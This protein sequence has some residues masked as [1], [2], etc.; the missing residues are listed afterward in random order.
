MKISTKDELFG[1]IAL[2]QEKDSEAPDQKALSNF[3]PAQASKG[4]KQLNPKGS[5]N[6]HSFKQMKL[7]KS[8][9][10]KQQS[11]IKEEPKLE[12]KKSTG[13]FKIEI[14]AEEPRSDNPENNQKEEDSF[15]TISAS[16]QDRSDSKNKSM[17]LNDNELP[18]LLVS[19]RRSTSKQ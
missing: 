18:G 8:R 12:E 3:S 10:Q 6:M 11:I 14:I 16:Y 13:K 2:T 5:K 4:S 15:V 19:N 1:I 17:L 7:S 9:I